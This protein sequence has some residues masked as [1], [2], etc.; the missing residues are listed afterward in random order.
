V[1]SRGAPIA[2]ASQARSIGSHAAVR[3]Q[4]TLERC[5]PATN[6]QGGQTET[7]LRRS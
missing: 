6:A 1:F 3:L 4:W 2:T 7:G 5:A